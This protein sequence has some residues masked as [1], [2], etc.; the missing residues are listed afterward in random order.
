MGPEEHCKRRLGHTAELG[1][2]VPL[3]DVLQQDSWEGEGEGKGGGG[4]GRGGEGREGIEVRTPADVQWV[5]G[6]NM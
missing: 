4:E 5:G 1:V 3:L 6:R 2:G